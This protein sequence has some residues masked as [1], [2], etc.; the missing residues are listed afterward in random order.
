[1]LK[2]NVKLTGSLAI[3]LNGVVVRKVDNLVVNTGLDHF[4]NRLVSGIDTAMSHMA[5]GTDGSAITASGAGATAADNIALGSLAHVQEFGTTTL[6]SQDREVT[7]SS[8]FAA[9]DGDGAL[10]EA[11][12]FNGSDSTT[13]TGSAKMLARTTF[14][15]VNKGANDTMTITWTITAS[16]GS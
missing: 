14:S 5:V 9:G 4:T 15:E 2:G 1:M 6:T 12:I 16:A 13:S 8:E 7:F 10:K 3:A 11:G